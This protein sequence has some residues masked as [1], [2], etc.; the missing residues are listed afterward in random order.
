MA[1]FAACCIP[2]QL[3]TVFDPSLRTA[4][5]YCKLAVGQSAPLCCLQSPSSAV[6]SLTDVFPTSVHAD[7]CPYVFLVFCPQESQFKP[8][9][10]GLP[11][12][13]SAFTLASAP[14]HAA[15]WDHFRSIDSDKEARVLQVNEC[16]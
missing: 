12:P 10:F 9:P 6:Y 1:L 5:L 4:V 14:E 2:R 16:M 3:Q 11:A 7:L 13:P 8:I 15:V